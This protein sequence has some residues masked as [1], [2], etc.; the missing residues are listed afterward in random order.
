MAAAQPTD[1][2]QRGLEDLV[3]R[4]FGTPLGEGWGPGAVV[5]LLQALRTLADSELARLQSQ[6]V[7][8]WPRT[9]EEIDPDSA[10]GQRCAQLA[11]ARGRAWPPRRA[12][13]GPAIPQGRARDEAYRRELATLYELLRPLTAFQPETVDLGFVVQ[14]QGRWEPARTVFRVI[15]LAAQAAHHLVVSEQQ[16]LA[17]EESQASGSEVDTARSPE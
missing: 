16:R 14:V 8:E 5:L 1:T 12:E 17:R 3:G 15:G 10:L 2:Y 9:P 6:G 11:A 4:L 7:A 13:P